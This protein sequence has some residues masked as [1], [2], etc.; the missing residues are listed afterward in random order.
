MP[1]NERPASWRGDM[2]EEEMT[3][4]DWAARG[5]DQARAML[6]AQDPFLSSP[7]EYGLPTGGCYNGDY[8]QSYQD[9]LNARLDADEY[10]E[11]EVEGQLNE[12]NH[13]QQ[14]S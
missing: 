1:E 14:E 2:G 12:L 13:Y 7:D 11:A 4:A 10:F 3:E 5:G 9:E 8:P 6:S